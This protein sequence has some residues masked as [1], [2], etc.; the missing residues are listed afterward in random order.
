MEKKKISQKTKK[1][2]VEWVIIIGVAWLLAKGVNTFVIEKVKT[3]TRS[4][5]PTIMVG[6]KYLMN[7]LAYLFSSPKRGDIVIFKDPNE[8]SEDLFK[9]V[10][11]LPGETI[12]F[13]DGKVFIDGELLEEDYVHGKETLDKGISSYDIPENCYFMMGDNR[14]GSLDARDWDQPFVDESLIKGKVF[15]RYSPSLKWV[16]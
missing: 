15:L 12:S 7:K 13:S 11:G 6:E 9:R 4:M 14:T 1:T 3:P 8:P 16:N 2:I 10:I 5:E